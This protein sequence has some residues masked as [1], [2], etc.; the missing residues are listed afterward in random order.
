MSDS[1]HRSRRHFL[2]TV[3][4]FGFT[5]LFGSQLCHA[6][7]SGEPTGRF[8]RCL[9]LWMEGGPS[10]LDTFDPKVDARKSIATNVPGVRFAETLPGL[11]N[12]ADQLCLVRSV[13]SSEGEHARATELLHTGFTPVP[14]F[15][16]PALGAMVAADRDVGD[17]PR[18]VTLGGNGMGPAFLGSE[19]GPFVVDD[20]SAA[21][22]QL[23][24]V[25]QNRGA[26][27]LLERLN[28]NRQSQLDVAALGNRPA[29]VESVSRLFG[30]DFPNALDLESV[31][32]KHWERYGDSTFS[33]RVYTARRLLALGVPFVEAQLGGWDTHIDN[34]RR[35]SDLCATIE[36]PWLALMDD[37]QAEGMWDDTLIVWMGEFGRTPNI[38]NRT[39]RDHYPEV[40]PIVLAGGDLGG[41]VVGAT[42]EAGTRRVG[43]KNSV[44]DFM[45]TLME[46]LGLDHEQEYMTSFGSP[47]TAT[48]DGTPIAPL[49]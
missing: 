26:L 11:A 36:K 46:L 27:D 17:V 45:A 25:D 24:R 44:A 3:S 20:I 48:D 7:S 19:N 12:R 28:R 49:L 47:T 43:Q 32:A 6:L 34:D 37:L 33:Q 29:A 41:R 30:T 13:G 16:R 22:Q 31:D 10:Q 21:H 39:G 42:S 15:P 18:Y 40:T 9:V 38:N 35:T 2:S 5:S 8:K 14:S 1:S 4:A 23:K